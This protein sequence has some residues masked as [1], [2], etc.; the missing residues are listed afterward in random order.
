MTDDKKQIMYLLLIL[1]GIEVLLLVL[2]EPA[3]SFVNGGMF[4]EYEDALLEPM[5]WGIG[6]LIPTIFLLFFKPHIFKNWLYYIA[7][8]Y[9]PVSIVLVSQ[10]SIYSSNVLSID[11]GP[12]A[13]YLMFGLFLITAV[14]AIGYSRYQKSRL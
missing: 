10:I 12:A 8:W 5:F 9:V 3:M 1:V 7:S 11:R 4:S 2:A 13:L 14:Y 6:T